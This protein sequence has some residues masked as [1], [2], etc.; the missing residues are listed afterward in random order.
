MKI[1]CGKESASSILNPMLHCNCNIWS[2]PNQLRY[3]IT[4]CIL[5]CLWELGKPF[6]ATACPLTLTKPHDS[7][8]HRSNRATPSDVPSLA[9]S[10]LPF[11]SIFSIRINSPQPR[12][13]AISAR[14]FGLHGPAPK[15]GPE[16]TTRGKIGREPP[17]TTPCSHAFSR[18]CISS[19][20]LRRHL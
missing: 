20:S 19:F 14:L 11:W 5:P 9:S 15:F 3:W 4:L 6:T 10:A 7:G 18:R 16:A 1:S 12:S 17:A 13:V 8:Q 2:L